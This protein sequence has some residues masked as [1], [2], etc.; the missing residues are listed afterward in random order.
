MSEASEFRFPSGNRKRDKVSK[1]HTKRMPSDSVS[2]KSESKS[3][4]C[5]DAASV[6]SAETIN[7]EYEEAYNKLRREPVIE[8][9][10]DSCCLDES[11]TAS[12]LQRKT[13]SKRITEI[14]YE[15]TDNNDVLEK[16]SELTLELEKLKT[17]TQPIGVDA[18]FNQILRNVDNL[19]T[20]QKQA[21]VNA[22]VNSMN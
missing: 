11:F 18:A 7:S 16:L 21:L 22:I 6:Y 12:E 15:H 14:R 19:N 8:E 10:N 5:D 3:S 2:I 20:K 4:S 13:K 9:S 1:T 17:A